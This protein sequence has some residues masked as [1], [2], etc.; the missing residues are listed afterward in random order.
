MAICSCLALFIFPVPCSSRSSPPTCSPRSS[1]LPSGQAPPSP[2]SAAKEGIKEVNN[3]LNWTELTSTLKVASAIL[4]YCSPPPRAREAWGEEKRRGGEGEKRRGEEGEGDS[5]HS[6][7][8]GIDRSDDFLP[9]WHVNR[10]D[11]SPD[12]TGHVRRCDN[13]HCEMLQDVN[14]SDVTCMHVI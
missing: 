13:T 5:D 2:A 1:P 9:V 6:G 11:A 4:S 12:V 7:D 10:C 3:Q 14:L 8:S